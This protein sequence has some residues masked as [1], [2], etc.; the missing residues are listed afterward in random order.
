MR[1]TGACDA[2]NLLQA[3]P[4]VFP[5]EPL[6]VRAQ[7]Q[8]AYNQCW[9]AVSKNLEVRPETSH[10]SAAPIPIEDAKELALQDVLEETNHATFQAL[11]HFA[12]TAHQAPDMS[13]SFVQRS[14]VI[15]TALTFAGGVNSADHAQ[16]F[17]TLVDLLRQQVIFSLFPARAAEAHSLQGSTVLQGCFGF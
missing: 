8:E 11:L 9:S 14:R 12:A 3:F 2:E 5:E 1:V 7:R 6:E 13:S 16:T 4:P 15:P 10:E 17:P